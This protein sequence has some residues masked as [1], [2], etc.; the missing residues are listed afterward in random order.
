LQ[1]DI[2]PTMRVVLL[3]LVVLVGAGLFLSLVLWSQRPGNLPSSFFRQLDVNHDGA[4]AFSEWQA[5]HEEREDWPGRQWDFDFMDC[6]DDQRLTWSEY[7]NNVFRGQMCKDPA[8]LSSRP[9]APGSF[10]FCETNPITG[11]QTCAVG[12]GRGDFTG[13]SAG[14]MQRLEIPQ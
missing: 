14:P 8:L 2:L 10:H 5:Y 3:S 1:S 9:Q 7:R 4:V 12:S 6:N 13:P 11:V